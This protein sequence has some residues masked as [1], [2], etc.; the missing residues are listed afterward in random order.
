MYGNNIYIEQ[1][2]FDVKVFIDGIEIE[3]IKGVTYQGE[4]GEMPLVN[5]AFY[6]AMF[7]LD[8]KRGKMDEN[9]MDIGLEEDDI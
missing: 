1:T 7:E 8:T 2:G 3:R 4:A 5:V 6:P 9:G